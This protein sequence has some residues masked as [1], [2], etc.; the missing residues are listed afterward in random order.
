MTMRTA[1]SR[2]A[3][4]KLPAYTNTTPSVYNDNKGT[5]FITRL[6]GT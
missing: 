3:I 4:W 5:P 1:N 2:K 6:N